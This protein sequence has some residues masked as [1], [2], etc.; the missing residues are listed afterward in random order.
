MPSIDWPYEKLVDY[1]PES[2]ARDDFDAF[3]DEALAASGRT[4]LRADFQALSDSMPGA[5]V[6]DVSFDGV[7][8]VRVRGWYVTP[9][10]IDRPL[11]AVVKF[12]GYSGGRD[13]PHDLAH[14]VLNGFCAFIMDSRGQGGGDG[15]AAG[16]QF[17]RTTGLHHAWDSG[18]AGILL[19]QLLSGHGESRGGGGRAA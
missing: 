12:I 16:H 10:Q 6:F 11:P 2:T 14:Y 18:S 1:R 9:P 19:S 17:R 4:E 7:D 13:Y 8:G 5:R 3:W 15:M